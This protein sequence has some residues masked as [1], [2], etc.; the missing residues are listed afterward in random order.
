MKQTI[1]IPIYP[2]V[3]AVNAKVHYTARAKSTTPETEAIISDISEGENEDMMAASL[4]KATGR[5][6]DVIRLYVPVSITRTGEFGSPADEDDQEQAITAEL[7]L[8]SNYDA[9]HLPA[10]EEAMAQYCQNAILQDWFAVCVPDSA[11]H[12][13]Q[14]QTEAIA[15]IRTALTARVRPRYENETPILDTYE[16]IYPTADEA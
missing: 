16:L 14:Q 11:S 10:L 8:P 12:Y 2:I 6:A 7:T 4:G 1:T 9:S 13:A 5:M 3:D 15:A